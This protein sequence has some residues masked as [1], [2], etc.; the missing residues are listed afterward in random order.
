[1]L[2]RNT[3]ISG[4]ALA[5]E[6]GITKGYYYALENGTRGHKITVVMLARITELLGVDAAQMMKDEVRYQEEW[7]IYI[8]VKQKEKNLGREMETKDL[9]TMIDEYINYMDRKQITKDSYK[10]ILLEYKTTL[11]L[12]Q[13]QI[14]S[15][16]M[17]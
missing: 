11:R 9:K 13:F 10:R 12:Y 14:Q 5:F 6:L 4:E 7:D 1:M 17:C 16:M 8:E 2:R 3:N 15:V